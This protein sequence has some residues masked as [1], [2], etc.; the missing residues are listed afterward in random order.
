MI[1][2]LQ[3]L[4]QSNG[5]GRSSL[6]PVLFSNKAIYYEAFYHTPSSSE[7]ESLYKVQTKA[8]KPA[9]NLPEDYK[10]AIP[11][12]HLMLLHG[13]FYLLSSTW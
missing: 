10:K 3:A 12:N 11:S 13:R 8:E 7:L 6:P 4:L 2:F 5:D 1:N 9:L